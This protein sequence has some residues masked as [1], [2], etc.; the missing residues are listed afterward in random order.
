M[1]REES[2]GTDPGTGRPLVFG[3]GSELQDDLGTC[4]PERIGFGHSGAGGSVH[5]GWP[6]LGVAFSHTPCT[7]GAEGHD[8]RAQRLLTAL[9]AC[10]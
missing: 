7:M 5:G 3:L 4:G 1:H 2:R 8:G 9:H 6:R 10:L